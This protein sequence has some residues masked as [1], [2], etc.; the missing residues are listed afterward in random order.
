MTRVVIVGGAGGTNVGGSLHRAGQSIGLDVKLIN[1]EG[2]YAGPRIV[3][4]ALWRLA[5]RP[6]LLGKFSLNAVKIAVEMKASVLITT[7][8]APISRSCLNRLRGNGVFC[9]NFSTDDPWNPAH[10]ARW[11]LRALPAYDIIYTPRCANIKDFYSI[12]CAQVRY[13]P[14]GY[15]SSLFA[16]L[17]GGRGTQQREILFVGGADKDR[18]QFFRAFLRGSPHL[19]LVLVGSYWEQYQDLRRL[20][21]GQLCPDAVSQATRQ[22]AVNL[23]LVRRA[24]RDGHVM[25]SFEIPAVG[26]FMIV[27]DSKDHRQ[28]FGTEG[29][30]V[31]YFT[32]AE[33]AAEKVE[34][35]LA[36]PLERS[37]MAAACQRRI[38]D[39]KHTY[40]HRLM[41][42]LENVAQ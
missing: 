10:C 34:K 18:A 36:R 4:R 1:H 5:K 16:P 40:Q 23:C 13:L 12:G 31:L 14:F 28:F 11:F 37:K 21:R 32:S 8:A 29:R 33:E 15:D 19:P 30:C 22:A 39:A 27:E 7:G 24:N 20:S 42:M 41:T 3:Q 9:I 6:I 38:L 17:L 26:G 35:A 25:R 2:A